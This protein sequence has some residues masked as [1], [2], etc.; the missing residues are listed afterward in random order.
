[1]KIHGTI[2]HEAINFIDYIF[3][4]TERVNISETSA[5]NFIDYINMMTEAVNISET[6]VCY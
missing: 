4:M 6:S 5:I 1:M 3:L 2:P